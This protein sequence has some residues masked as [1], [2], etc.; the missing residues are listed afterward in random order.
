MVDR[1]DLLHRCGCAEAASSVVTQDTAQAFG[2]LVRAELATYMQGLEKQALGRN[3]LLGCIT[4]VTQYSE[5]FPVEENTWICA[6]RDAVLAA[7]HGA[8]Q[9]C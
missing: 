6:Q 8:L 2:R 1:D 3:D 7:L 4:V 9:E 5:Q